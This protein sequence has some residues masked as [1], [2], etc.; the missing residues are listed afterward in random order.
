MTPVRGQGRAYV[1]AIAALALVNL[2]A[3]RSDENAGQ[4]DSASPFGEVGTVPQRTIAEVL[5]EHASELL[6]IEGVVGAYEGQLDDGASCIK[7]AVARRSDAL[8]DRVPDSLEGYPVVLVE[9]GPIE[10]K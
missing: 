1:L 7:V 6:A 10:P 3:C 2:W 5:G 9:T 8:D 4:R